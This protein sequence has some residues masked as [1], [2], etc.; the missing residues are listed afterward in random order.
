VR[1][2]GPGDVGFLDDINDFDAGWMH[3]LALDINGF[4][5]AWGKNHVGQLGD[6]GEEDEQ[7]W[8]SDEK[9]RETL[10]GAEFQ[11]FIDE[12]KAYVE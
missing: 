6:G 3:S 10:T 1:V 12:L 7:Q 4:V 9:L 11:K 2:H 8:Q 5:W